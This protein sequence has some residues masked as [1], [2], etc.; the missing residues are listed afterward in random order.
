MMEFEEITG[1]IIGAAYKVFNTLGFGFLETV[2][3]KALA[4]ELSRT[5]LKSLLS[6]R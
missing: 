5:G 1:K 2:Y 6:Q 4:I 3:K